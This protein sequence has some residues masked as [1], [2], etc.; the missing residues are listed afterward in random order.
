TEERRRILALD[1]VLVEIPDSVPPEDHGSARRR[2]N[3]HQA[4]ARVGRHRRDK[5]RMEVLELLDREAMV[6]AGE[7]DKSKVPRADHGDRGLVCRW[8]NLLLVEVDDAICR[9]VREGGPRH[10]RTDALAARDLR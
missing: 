6:V 5:V 2:A 7:P 1:A 4:D 8:R 3:H 10:R 9:L